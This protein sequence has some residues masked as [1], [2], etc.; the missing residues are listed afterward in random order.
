MIC[1]KQHSQGPQCPPDSLHLRRLSSPSNQAFGKHFC[2]ELSFALAPRRAAKLDI[3][4]KGCNVFVLSTP[5]RNTVD[6]I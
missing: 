5:T 6:L 1:S 2:T 3:A 4:L